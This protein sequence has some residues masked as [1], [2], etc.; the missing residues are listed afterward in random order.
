MIM[1]K[2]LIDA[3]AFILNCLYSL[4]K[5]LPVQKKITYISRQSNVI[6]TDFQLVISEMKKRHPEYRNVTLIKMI[7]K[8]FPEKIEYCFHMF[9]QMYHAAT[10]EIVVLDTYC[11]I[12]SLLK[13]RKSL[14]VIQMWHAIG[15]MKKFGYSILD[16][17]EGTKRDIA[18]AMRMHQNYSFVFSSSSFCSQ[19][20]AEAFHVSMDQMV[21]MPL[22]RL[23]LLLD[24]RYS[25]KI[26][27]QIYE[28]YPQLLG[29]GKKT[30]VYAPTFRKE[31]GDFD[32]KVLKKAAEDL[33]EN[34]NFE[35]YN[36]VVKFH[37]LSEIKLCCESV[38]QDTEFSTIDFCRV[39]DFVILD[40]SAIVFEAALLGKPL[41]FYAFDYD[42]YMRNR[43]VYI[44]FKKYVPGEIA[45]TPEKLMELIDSDISHRE[46]LEA[47]RDLMIS[48]PRGRSYT[49]DVVDFFEN[50]LMDDHK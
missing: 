15:A 38:I 42:T 4:M 20:F 37:P 21:V 25:E 16:K 8:S 1:K 9:R 6:P 36:L 22:P 29:N 32:D 40:Y 41:F 3:A 35:R 10:S 45:E 14:K 48:K 30:I 13:Q 11:I 50:I 19:F 5:L 7:G 28:R 24:K 34:V 43:D 17:G 23:D 2:K 46:K 31:G 12:I 44:D 39:A 47:F 27:K 49:D 33:E 18:D 26:E